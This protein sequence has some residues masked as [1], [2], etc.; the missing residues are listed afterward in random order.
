M[1]GILSFTG[2]FI[3]SKNEAYYG[4]IKSNEPY[5]T[6]LLSRNM[7]L[8]ANHIDPAAGLPDNNELYYTGAMNFKGTDKI[9]FNSPDEGLIKRI[10]IINR[11]RNFSISTVTDAQFA[12]DYFIKN[13]NLRNYHLVYIDSREN[14]ITI[15]PIQ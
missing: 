11:G 2:D 7:N 8:S 3:S 5:T 6:V 15:K 4:I 14:C 12:V 1:R 10:D 13:L 9:F